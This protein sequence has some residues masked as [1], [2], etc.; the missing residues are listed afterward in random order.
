MEVGTL[1]P[2][3]LLVAEEG[4][5]RQIEGVVVAEND[6]KDREDDLKQ[7]INLRADAV[8]SDVSIIPLDK[9]SFESQ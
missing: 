2:I 8:F 9:A 3:E 4:V 7:V 5:A 6:I 1:A